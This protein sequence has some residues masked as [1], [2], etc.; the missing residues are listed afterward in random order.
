[1]HAIICIRMPDIRIS[2]ARGPAVY[3]DT[4]RITIDVRACAISKV[5][6]LIFSRRT[7]SDI[8]V[9]RWERDR[10]SQSPVATSAAPTGASVG[11]ISILRVYPIYLYVYE[12]VYKRRCSG[13]DLKYR[14][15]D[16]DQGM[17]RAV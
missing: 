6:A 15:K 2:A 3:V 9:S 4:A 7:F 11:R 12:K 1:M 5:H 10:R 17:C 8:S 16:I 14:T 13:H